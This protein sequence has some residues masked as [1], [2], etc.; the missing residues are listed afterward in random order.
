MILSRVKFYPQERVDLEDL[1][2]LL[3]AAR[4]DAKFW[5]K[6]FLSGENYILKGLTVSGVGLTSGTIEMDNATLILGQGT[7][8]FS[9][10]ISEAIPTD[11]TI[12][13]SDLVDGVRNYVELQ[14]TY[15][16][17]TPITKAF[18]DPSANGGLGAE[19]N[20]QVNTVTDL[21]AEVVV[22]QGG[23]T[24]NPDRV[25]VA[26]IDTNGSG[27][28]KV[29]LDRRSQFFRLG[30]PANP[31]NEFTWAS[32]EEPP[33]AINLT[34]VAGTY[35]A[36]ETVTFSGGATAVV[37]V[38]GTTNISVE[39]PSNL[40][41]ASGNTLTGGTSGATGTV[42]TIVESF[43][44]ADKDIGD[45]KEALSALQ[46]EIKRLKGTR[47]WHQ[48]QGNSMQGISSFIN[49]TL[50]NLTSDAKYT[51][52]GTQLSI[53]DSNGAPAS[54]DNLAK[55]KLFGKSQ[56]LNLR[57]QDGQASTSLITVN[58]GQVLFI[59]LPASGNRN[60]SGIGAG[61]TNYQV[62][63]SD[64]FEIND[65]N[66]WIAYREGTR[67]YARG[68]GELMAGESAEISDNI[69][70]NILAAIGLSSEIA[71]PNYTSTNYVTQSSSLVAAMSRLDDRLEENTNLKMLG[72][73]TW[74]NTSGSLSFTEPAYIQVPGLTN[75][76]NTI[77]TSQS[78]IVFTTSTQVA[79]VVPNRTAGIDA[80][81][82]VVVAEI[83][84]LTA[85]QDRVIIA[86]NS[87][88]PG[89]S[90]GTERSTLA[91]TSPINSVIDNDKLYVTG[92][93]ALTIYDVSD[94]T[95][96]TLL[97][98]LGGFTF[99][100]P[101]Y[102]VGN[103]AYIGWTSGGA[104][105]FSVV[106]VTTPSAP[107]LSGTVA[108]GSG[109]ALN[110][111]EV[112]GVRAFVN[113]QSGIPGPT[114]VGD[115]NVVDVSVPA[116]PTIV[117]SNTTYGGNL[118]GGNI[119]SR[120]AS[121]HLYKA[122][123]D[124]VNIFDGTTN[125]ATLLADYMAGFTQAGKVAVNATH[126]F[127]T[128]LST[129]ELTIHS[130][131]SPAAPVLVSTLPL[132][133]NPDNIRVLGNIA[134]ISHTLSDA[135]T[136]VNISN[137]A[138][139]TIIYSANHVVSSDW[140]YPNDNIVFL[141]GTTSR[142]IQAIAET[143]DS[144]IIVGSHSFR[145]LDGQSKALDAGISDQNRELLGGT[146]TPFDETTTDPEWETRGSPLRT[147]SNTDSALD[148]TA[149]IDAELDKFFGQ[150]R[151]IPHET[152]AYKARITGVD[153]NLLDNSILSQEM[154]NLIVDFDGAVI[155]FN[156][157]AILKADDV[158]AL[159]INFTPFSIPS[160]QYF[161]YGIGIVPGTVGVDNRVGIQVLVTPASAANAVQAS[162]PF[163]AISGTKRLGAVQVR[164]VSS[165][166]ELQVIRQLGVGSG[167]SGTGS[168][169]ATFLDPVSTVLPSGTSVTID[170]VSGVNGDLVLF[171]KLVSNNNRIYKLSGVGVA[172]AWEA[173]RA[174]D[175]SFDPTDGDSVRILKGDS[176]K[177]QLAVFDSVNF[178]VND[179]LRFFDGV[180]ADYWELG[181]VKT[182]A[183]LDNTTDGIVFSVTITGSE[184]WI[185]NYSVSRGA[186][187]K[188][189]GQ[190]LITSDGTSV[191]ITDTNA[192]LGDTGVEFSADIDSG[193]I[194]L[195]YTTT[196]TGTDAAMKLFTMRWGN[197][198]GGPGGVPNYGTSPT[199]SVAAAGAI[200]DVQYKGSSGNLSGDTDFKWDETENAINLNGLLIKALQGPV[201]LLDNQTDQT[202]FSYNVSN[203]YA[204]IEYSILR[205]NATQVGRLLVTTN[206][207]SV[208]LSDDNTFV[209]VPGVTF[210]AAISGSDVL[211]RYTTSSNGFNADF[212]YSFRRW[213]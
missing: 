9:Y 57:R 161:W 34:G 30:T 21:Q 188:D 77:P 75:G 174:F 66:Y 95:A 59:K 121:T 157:G 39:L 22:V 79:Y 104:G 192:Y 124:R 126:L 156:T 70:S 183:L 96:P 44:G 106:D 144:A 33:Y 189:T 18:W 194:R 108:F 110:F 89:I 118:L 125:N 147:L 31:D 112:I 137:P 12:S 151:I 23:F 130:L 90:V 193:N 52:S 87:G 169:K 199:S 186:G 20:Q 67:L 19:F 51:W 101:L 102:V 127:I 65:E 78:P 17:G 86:R 43:T 84:S 191:A 142:F 203:K 25:P 42:N 2:T 140:L 128:D 180:G 100:G 209:G 167:G 74:L 54:T 62:I 113:F 47:F 164:N 91:L 4:T 184:N 58:D 177:E 41:F 69:N 15:E 178:K 181:S 190:L 187:L 76:R 143:G 27:I 11:L 14:L 165:N 135:L 32:N 172:I 171:T 46:T 202:I 111:I 139:P 26:I 138:S 53:T 195:L 204:I 3:S 150:F 28:I 98:S 116:T 83:D 212:K 68:N 179:T 88:S 36:G 122:G 8:D 166:S 134:Y 123:G 206:G 80:N 176:F 35:V 148:A 73:G 16:D 103:T 82:T 196:N 29:I 162:A 152:I 94:P 105:Q 5:T 200:G 40:N 208:S 45:V 85:S 55:L 72:G 136:L 71:L 155:N 213:S 149:S 115:I 198:S 120:S 197:G 129:E 153:K 141:Q 6:Q 175:S 211:I 60:Y 154:I 109:E 168:I 163:S 93:S 145:L 1:N 24:G 114:S 92:N 97:G 205:N 61:D 210:S 117:G 13:D 201:S 10:F 64:D 107:T 99:I 37:T 38:G 56:T 48:I 207:S 159:G 173:Q 49:A 132:A 7:Q 81:L 158:T 131:A 160:N 119:A 182:V 185:V 50:V 170:G 63:N 133:S 146:V